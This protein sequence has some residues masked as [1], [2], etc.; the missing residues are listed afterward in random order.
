MGY[1]LV[2]SM[3]FFA[4]LAVAIVLA[5]D[6][7]PGSVSLPRRERTGLRWLAIVA[8]DGQAPVGWPRPLLTALPLG[9][10]GIITEFEARSLHGR[11][12]AVDAALTETA[13]DVLVT[14][15]A[16]DDLMAGI[17]LEEHEPAL[18]QLLD[19]ARRHGAVP[20]V[21]GLPDLTSWEVVR[22]AALPPDELAG[23]RSRWNAS[24]DRL[25]DAADGLFVDLSDLRESDVSR[26]GAVAAHFLNPLRRALVMARHRSAS[27]PAR[28]V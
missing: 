6:R 26:V 7:A 5:V 8:R 22:A 23:V 16:L 11:C 3:A 14:W 17:S 24:I 1:W 4:V 28:R 13:P 9:V 15:H 25:T 27:A 10:E 12:A 19:T 2:I 20:V 18:R 21:G